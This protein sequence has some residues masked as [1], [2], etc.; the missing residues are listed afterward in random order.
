MKTIF[1]GGNRSFNS[2]L[3]V[4]AVVNAALAAGHRIHT[5]CAAGADALVVAAVL[6]ANAARSLSV[7]STLAPGAQLPNRLAAAWSAGA[8]VW[9]SRFTGRP[10]AMLAA[11]TRCALA[12]AQLCC[13]FLSEIKTT[14]G[15]Y[16]A[17]AAAAALGKQV[18]FFTVGTAATR[19]PVA[20][21]GQV[22][23]FLQ[24]SLWGFPCWRWVQSPSKK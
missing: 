2:N 4:A 18:V 22:G 7:F 1:L 16:K 10:A 17:A 3:V 23:F 11:R 20:L 6:A 15:S 5:G 14:S 9:W 24:S 13:W 19:P 8:Q 21:P 12:G